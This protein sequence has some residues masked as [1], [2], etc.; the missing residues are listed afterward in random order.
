MAAS[1]LNGCGYLLLLNLQYIIKIFEWGK[2]HFNFQAY[3]RDLN[4][5][6]V[7]DN[8]FY[9]SNTVWLKDYD[10]ILRVVSK[11]TTC[12]IQ[13]LLSN[14]YLSKNKSKYVITDIDHFN[15]IK[16]YSVF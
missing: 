1:D 5:F 4:M 3:Y 15:C 9:G 11:P 7:L 2:S 14:F 16:F 12:Q 8:R 13:G 10:E 6:F